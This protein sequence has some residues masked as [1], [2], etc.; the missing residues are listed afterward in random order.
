MAFANLGSVLEAAAMTT[1]DIVR[2]TVHTTDVDAL[3]AVY[4]SVA[5]ALA[6]NPPAMTLIGV[7]RL[8]SPEL[9]VEIEATAVQ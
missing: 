2:L 9:K 7:T 3:L 5:G 6:P 1:S 8:A 4:A